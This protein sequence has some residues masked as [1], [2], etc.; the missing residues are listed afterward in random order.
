[1]PSGFAVMSCARAPCVLERSE[2][3]EARS[4]QTALGLLH[5]TT[6][7]LLKP[8][9]TNTERIG[10]RDNKRECQRDH[11]EALYNFKRYALV[12]PSPI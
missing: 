9:A 3:R 7:G 10:V 1:M 4:K 12:P 8:R 6:M 2:K 5:D 11:Q